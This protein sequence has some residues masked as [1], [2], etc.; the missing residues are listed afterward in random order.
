MVK[1]IVTALFCLFIGAACKKDLAFTEARVLVVNNSRATVKAT[2]NAEALGN[3]LASPA[4]T[5]YQLL[6]PGYT[7]FTVSDAGSGVSLFT[8]NTYLNPGKSYSVFITGNHAPLTRVLL[9]TLPPVL[10]ETDAYIRYLNLADDTLKTTVYLNTAQFTVGRANDS[11]FTTTS[12][13]F[14]QITARSDTFRVFNTSTGSLLLD[15]VFVLEKSRAYTF[16]L[17]GSLTA[18]PKKLTLN[19]VNNN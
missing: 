15:S 14:T 5:S 18:N 9:D 8:G 16:F 3:S 10:S 11:S 13:L 12:T 4:A 17:S 1:Q 2:A 6:Q 19:K 7:S